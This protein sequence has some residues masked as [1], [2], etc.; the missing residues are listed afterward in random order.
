MRDAYFIF[1]IVGTRSG[2]DHVRRPRHAAITT[3]HTNRQTVH[4]RRLMGELHTMHFCIFINR[5]SK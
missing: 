4:P 1:Y 3:D 5:E 2:V